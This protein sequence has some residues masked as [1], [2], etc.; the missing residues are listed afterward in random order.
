MSDDSQPSDTWTPDT[1]AFVIN[2]IQKL[3]EMN[4]ENSRKACIYLFLMN[5]LGFVTVILSAVSSVMVDEFTITINRIIFLLLTI[6]NSL[7]HYYQ[8]GK[9]VYKCR[10][11]IIDAE[12]VISR[13][14]KILVLKS[15]KRPSSRTVLSDLVR[16]ISDLRVATLHSPTKE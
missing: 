1:E 3:E 15:N 13:Y 6:L 7:S 4:I 2:Q 14:R 10:K 5:L 16:D 12:I 11:S 8:F 9:K